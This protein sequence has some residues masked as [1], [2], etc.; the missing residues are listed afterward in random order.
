MALIGLLWLTQPVI[1]PD[2]MILRREDTLFSLGLIGNPA[3]RQEALRV[4]KA[5]LV[6]MFGGAA[7][8]A[9]RMLDRFT[10]FAD[11][12]RDWQTRTILD[13]AAGVYVDKTRTPVFNLASDD[14][15]YIAGEDAAV[16]RA[17]MRLMAEIVRERGVKLVHYAQPMLFIPPDQHARIFVPNYVDQLRTWLA[18][19]DV[20]L[21]VIEVG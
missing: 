11:H 14:D 1:D 2:R 20:D 3:K 16:N 18:G 9:R 21:K 19:F 4:M 17:Y 6:S 8:F 15:R 10:G 13:W 7:E 12:M 5:S